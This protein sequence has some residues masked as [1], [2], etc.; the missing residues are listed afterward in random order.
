MSEMNITI[1][2]KWLK[3]GKNVL[4][5]TNISSKVHFYDLK[6]TKILTKSQKCESLER[7]LQLSQNELKLP[8]T[9]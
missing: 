8:K 7:L 2:S 1:D 9:C 3:I 6:P 5:L 4:K